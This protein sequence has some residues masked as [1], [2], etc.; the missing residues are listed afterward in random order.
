MR[1]RPL[2]A[3]WWPVALGLLFKGRW[4]EA[5]HELVPEAAR[6]AEG[7]VVIGFG[8]GDEAVRQRQGQIWGGG[9]C[10]ADRPLY[11]ILNSDQ[12]YSRLAAAVADRINE[13]SVVEHLSGAE[14]V[15]SADVSKSGNGRFRLD[16]DFLSNGE[17]NRVTRRV[18]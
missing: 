18:L 16:I 12:Q 1:Q 6:W 13:L 17:W 3:C 10:Q 15:F 9:K 11:I 5:A 7:S 4:D 8:D 2:W 14:C